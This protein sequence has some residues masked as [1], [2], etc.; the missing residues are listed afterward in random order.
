[1]FGNLKTIKA[2]GYQS[3]LSVVN[4]F[5]KDH[6]RE[7]VA[8]GDL[9]AHVRKGLATS[10]LSISPTLIRVQLLAKIVLL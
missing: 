9:V 6:G 1:M 5:N 3:Y 4:I 8:M 2:S 10:H 7:P